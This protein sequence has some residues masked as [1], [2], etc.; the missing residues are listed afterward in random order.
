MIGTKAT[1]V[2]F[3]ASF[4]IVNSQLNIRVTRNVITTLTIITATV[5]LIFQFN[6]TN[7]MLCHVNKNDL[8]KI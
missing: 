1:R 5:V 2:N 6:L 7:R 4:S 8:M 3:T